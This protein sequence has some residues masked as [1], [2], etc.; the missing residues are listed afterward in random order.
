M[1]TRLVIAGLCLLVLGVAFC[2]AGL[3]ALRTKR[4]TGGSVRGLLGLLLLALA[5][6][7]AAISVGL[8]E[9]HALTLEVLDGWIGARPAGPAAPGPRR[10]RRRDQRRPAR[11]PCLDA[12]GAGGHGHDGA[13]GPAALPGDHRPPRPAARHVRPGRGCPLHGR[14]HSQV[15]P[16][17][18]PVGA[19]HRLRAG[20][21]GAPT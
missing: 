7:A 9:Y 8:R 17:D 15:A 1:P 14:A 13:P 12:G 11:I 5:G 6:L 20:P 18:E 3:A 21:G 16:L 2:R 10:A 4:W 19:P